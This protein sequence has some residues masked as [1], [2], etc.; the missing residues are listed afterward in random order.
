MTKKG[1]LPGM[2]TYMMNITIVSCA[3]KT[4]F[5][6]MHYQRE[7]YR[8]YKSK[9]YICRDCPELEKCTQNRQYTKTVTRHIW[10][11]YLDL[12]EHLRKTE[13]GKE[14]Y[15]MRKETIERVLLMQRKARHA[16]YAPPR[17]G[18]GFCLGEA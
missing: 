10:Q 7:G 2:R 17:S 4:R 5:S 18:P 16:L 12:V 13:R 15:A 8:E 1:N 9:S 11:E 3:R 6:V 14:L